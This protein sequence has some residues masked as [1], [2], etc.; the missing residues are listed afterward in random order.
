MEK[1]PLHTIL[2]HVRKLIGPPA[3]DALSDRQLLE[4]FTTQQ[5][6]AAFTALV[7]R[8][9]PLVWAV[10]RKI[11]AN[12][13]DAED[14]FQATFVVLLRKAGAIPWREAVGGWLHGV[15][16][17]VAREAKV[18]AL[19]CA[20]LQAQ[21]SA[22]TVPAGDNSA[23]RETRRV[24]DEELQQLPARHGAG[25]R[26]RDAVRTAGSDRPGR[27]P[28]WDGTDGI[29]TVSGPKTRLRC[30]LE[31]RARSSIARGP[32]QPGLSSLANKPLRSW[33]RW[34]PRFDR[35]S[36]RP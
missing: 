8:H 24:L 11:L 30:G 25:C 34:G 3:D 14:A 32:G 33:Q 13:P 1:Q 20:A 19:R 29:P 28:V 18:K 26:P 35:P 6:E 12:E 23:Q 7:R 10:Y 9:G 16:Y 36:S 5:D 27:F 2:W 15:A 31:S 4:R 21:V 17:R 22:M